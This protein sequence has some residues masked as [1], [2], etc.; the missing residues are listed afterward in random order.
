M[1]TRADSALQ[2]FQAIEDRFNAAMVSND[3]ARIGRCISPDWV[4]VTPE[5]GPIGR[6]AILQA[7]ASG[8]LSHDSMTKQVLRAEVYGDMAVVT[9][10]GSNTGSFR[11]MPISADE[12][13]TDVYRLA[14]GD[15][16]CVLTHLTPVVR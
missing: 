11:G 3:V 14:D 6:D 5:K 7:I 8:T 12:W 1:N 9:G 2:T 13:I 16:R 15:W 4:L 10:R